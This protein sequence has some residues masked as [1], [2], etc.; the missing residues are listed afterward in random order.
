MAE[1]QSWV[2]TEGVGFDAD[3]NSSAV[4]FVNEG[5]TLVVFR[6]SES[7]QARVVSEPDTSLNPVGTV[8]A[9]Y[10]CFDPEFLK[11]GPTWVTAWSGFVYQLRERDGKQV[12]YYEGAEQGFLR[13]DLLPP[14]LRAASV[15]TVIFHQVD[16]TYGLFEGPD[17]FKEYKKKKEI[18]QNA[19][20]GT[21]DALERT[22]I[23]PCGGWQRGA[24]AAMIYESTK[25]SKHRPFQGEQIP[26]AVSEG[27][28][29][30]RLFGS[31]IK[32]LGCLSWGPRITR[33]Q[34]EEAVAFLRTK[35]TSKS[36]D[37]A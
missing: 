10:N 33:Q 11:I 35:N 2:K 14:P 7:W 6:K 13:Q 22:G 16:G 19:T 27:C 12:W 23:A 36:V 9:N 29:F 34:F 5:D 25:D 20:V 21:Y 26:G 4:L 17:S 30:K 3:T 28:V 32:D 15:E 18:W 24:F 8:G 37:A 31:L 1:L